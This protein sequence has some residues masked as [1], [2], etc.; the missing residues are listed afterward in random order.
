MS[1]DSEKLAAAI[2]TIARAFGIRSERGLV[3]LTG[4][5]ILTFLLLAAVLVFHLGDI[6][7]FVF[8]VIMGTERP[9]AHD[10]DAFQLLFLAVILSL[11][12]LLVRERMA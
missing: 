2:A 9:L 7:L 8:S 11:V 4:E 1:L 3:L 12:F 6:F 10:F 5:V